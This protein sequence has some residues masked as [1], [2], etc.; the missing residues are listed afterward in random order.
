GA[1][2]NLR[3]NSQAGHQLGV[4]LLTVYRPADLRVGQLGLPAVAEVKES[5]TA[6]A[7]IDGVPTAVTVTVGA[8]SIAA[9]AA[10]GILA[11][12][13]T[14]FATVP[15]DVDPRA[16]VALHATNATASRDR[17][18]FLSAAVIGRG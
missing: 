1:I 17:T 8:T 12:T 2:L 14:P 10:G 11:R 4:L 16:G 15:A 3:A 13:V 18:R 6:L 7:E 9:P 5:A